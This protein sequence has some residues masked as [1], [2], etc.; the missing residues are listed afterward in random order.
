MVVAALAIPVLIG[1]AGLGTE[2]GFMYVK[3]SQV[4]I[5]T[6][7]AAL[8]GANAYLATS[9]SSVAAIEARAVAAQMGFVDGVNGVSVT[10]NSPPTSGSKSGSAS[11]TEVSISVSQKPLLISMFRSS[12]YTITGR[13]VS[14]T[15]ATGNGCLLALNSTASGAIS[16]GGSS[17]ATLSSCNAYSNS[18]SSSSVT[19]SGSSSLTA[20]TVST[21]GGIPAGAN[22]TA[23][24]LL[25]GA[26]AIADPYSTLSAPSYTGCNYNNYSTHNTV[27]LS[28][29]VY[30]N[31]LSLGSHASATLSPG[32]YI[33]DR[34]TFDVGAQATASGTDVTIILTSSTGA[35]YARMSVGG[36]G[37][38][39]LKAPSTGTYAGIAVYGDRNMPQGTSM[40]LRGGS[41]QIIGGA[42]YLP[43][44]D[45][46]YT[47]NTSASITCTQ[48][49]AD[50]LAFSGNSS[51]AA[52]CTGYGTKPFGG[53]S[54]TIVE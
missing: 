29:G 35:D 26:A 15:G 38:V 11:A 20:S 44:A 19:A 46:T 1:F 28:P 13:T 48:L 51:L 23:T 36:G 25:T 39:S 49:I 37:S 50:T 43:K 45:L 9:S 14:Q 31:G 40:S 27:T 54:T 10:V 4:Q 24:T 32:V 52:N 33:I 18:N 5:A 34:G 22:I 3:H 6:D 21:V 30:C 8:S 53:S 16:F 41:G 47:G 17:V 12:N 2:G 7:A 42:V